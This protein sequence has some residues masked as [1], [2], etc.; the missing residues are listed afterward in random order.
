MTEVFV[1][2]RENRTIAKHKGAFAPLLLL[3][4]TFQQVNTNRLFAL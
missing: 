1:I 2:N 4:H 3:R